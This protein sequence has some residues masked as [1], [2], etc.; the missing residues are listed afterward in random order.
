MIPSE[1][2][3]SSSHR[4]MLLSSF[5]GVPKRRS[6]PNSF[7][8]S[9]RRI[10]L[11]FMIRTKPIATESEEKIVIIEDMLSIRLR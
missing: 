4:I 10:F 9:R 8:L 3:A 6:V 5:E 2:S 1:K 7:L 11:M